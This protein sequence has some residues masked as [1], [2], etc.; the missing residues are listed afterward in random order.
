MNILRRAQ[1]HITHAFLL[2]SLTFVF[3]V[4]YWHKCVSW[5]ESHETHQVLEAEL[6]MSDEKIHCDLCDL[7]FSQFIAS[8]YNIQLSQPT[9]K[10]LESIPLYQTPFSITTI[11]PLLRAP[12][13]LKIS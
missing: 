11:L 6:S 7:V 4:K 2:L 12:P 13:T 3:P 10:I 8:D 5:E 1:K 9:L